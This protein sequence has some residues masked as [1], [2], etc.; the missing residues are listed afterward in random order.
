VEIR[1]GYLHLTDAPGLGIEL[2]EDALPH[3][4]VRNWRR[5]PAWRPD[6]AADFI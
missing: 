1:D 6:G 4:P 3:R 5:T 2:N